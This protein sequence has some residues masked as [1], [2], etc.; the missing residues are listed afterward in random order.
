MLRLIMTALLMVFCS[1]A[2]A[3]KKAER[4]YFVRDAEDPVVIGAKENTGKG[5]IMRDPNLGSSGL[6]AEK[7]AKVNKLPAKPVIVQKKSKK[8]SAIA[9]KPLRISATLR[10]PRVEFGRVALPVG[11]REEL[12]STDFISKSLSEMP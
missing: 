5:L 8:P 9:F 4:V 1:V 10:M 12:P 2:N 6:L 7:K 11:I 3:A